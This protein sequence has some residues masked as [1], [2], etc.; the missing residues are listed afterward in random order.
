MASSGDL[1]WM[2]SLWG[3]LGGLIYSAPKFSA[4]LY[5]A[6]EAKRGW[7]WCFLEMLVAQI[8]ASIASALLAPWII[9]SFHRSPEYELPALSGII[10]LVANRTAPT[11]IEV[12]NGNLL[13]RLKGEGA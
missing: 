12:V 8:V 2:A 11:V 5:A 7:T 6:R 3:F 4:C 10:G 1:A 9:F 13:K